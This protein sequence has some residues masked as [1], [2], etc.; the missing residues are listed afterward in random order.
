MKILNKN[1]LELVQ[2]LLESEYGKSKVQATNN[3]LVKFL[4]PE[5]HNGVNEM[6]VGTWFFKVSPKNET[7]LRVLVY[8]DYMEAF[9]H[10]KA[11]TKPNKEKVIDISEFFPNTPKGIA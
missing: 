3:G 7:T 9:E 6:E 8:L 4:F 11:G 1:T 2:D 5:T 10:L